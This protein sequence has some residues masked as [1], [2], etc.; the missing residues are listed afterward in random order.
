MKWNLIIEQMQISRDDRI[1]PF[2]FSTFGY[3]ELVNCYSTSLFSGFC[4]ACRLLIN[5]Y[6][7]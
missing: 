7:M 1:F 4:V 6:N 3:A 5:I 2:F